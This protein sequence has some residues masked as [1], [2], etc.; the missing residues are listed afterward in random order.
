MTNVVDASV[1]LKWLVPE[2][3]SLQ[4][5]ELL[6]QPV[7][8]PD[9]LISECVNALWKL[10]IRGKLT[11]TVAANAARLLAAAGIAFE[12][13]QGLARDILELAVRLRH[14][15]YDCTYL[16]LAQRLDAVLVT[17]DR[18]LFARCQQPDAADLARHVRLLDQ[19]G[20]EVQ[21]PRARKYGYRV[22]PAA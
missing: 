4:A 10:V 9:L 18:K 12:P 22:R 17:A 5:A 19:A 7:V 8:A 15:A 20:H 1:V 14:P 3:G 13:T 11:A 16:A 21:E 6:R 2:E